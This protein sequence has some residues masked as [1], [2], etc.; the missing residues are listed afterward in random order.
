MKPTTKTRSKANSKAMQ[1]INFTGLK[2]AAAR[3][4]FIIR[5]AKETILNFSKVTI[6]AL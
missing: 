4:Y 1:P 2:R 6:K 3:M 5:E